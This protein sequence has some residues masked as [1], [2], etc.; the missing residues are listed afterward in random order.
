MH[1]SAGSKIDF[2]LHIQGPKPDPAR[3]SSKTA[4]LKTTSRIAGGYGGVCHIG[5]RSVMIPL[6][7]P[8]GRVIKQRDRFLLGSIS[9]QW[10]V[11]RDDPGPL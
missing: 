4:H 7:S 9:Q 8:R 10:S 6:T 3:Q 11:P 2:W 1:P 5:V